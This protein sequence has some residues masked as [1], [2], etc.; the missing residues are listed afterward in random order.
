[1]FLIDCFYRY[2][3]ISGAL[4]MNKNKFVIVT[5]QRSGS[6]MLVSMIDSHPQIRC[7]GELMRVTPDWMKRDGYRGVLRMLEKVDPVYREDTFR[8]AHPHDFV[9]AVF[10]LV[11]NRQSY[12][13]KQHLNQNPDFLYSLI[14]DPDWNIL[15]LDRENKLAQYSS[16]KVSQATGQGNAPKGTKIIRVQ[17]EF[18]ENEFKKFVKQKEKEWDVIKQKL[19]SNGKNYFTIRYTDLISRSA[20]ESM[21]QFLGVDSLFQMDPGTEKR[22]SSDILSRFSNPEKIISVLEQMGH[23]EWIKEI[24]AP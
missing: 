11:P 13:F 12:G 19:K 23:S 5:S 8:F 18:K 2:D 1:M 17:V 16:Q 22:N 14:K 21:L 20:K 24:F 9:N 4:L 10:S 15:L 6:N 3:F 7:F